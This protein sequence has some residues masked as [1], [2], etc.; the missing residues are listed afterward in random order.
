MTNKQQIQNLRDYAELAWASYGYFHYFL[1]QH[2][3]PHY[4][5]KV[6]YID[7]RDE[8][9]KDKL[10]NNKEKV[11]RPI[12]LID[13][14]DINYNK[15]AVFEYNSFIK[16][17][18]KVGE[19]NGDMTLGQIKHFFERYDLL[20]H[21]PN[22]ESGFSAT[23]FGEKQTNKQ[24]QEKSSTSECGYV[25]YILAIRGT[26]FK[27]NQAWEDIIATDGSL[28]LSSTPKAQYDD[29]IHFYESCVR[30]YPQIKDKDSLTL[31]GH[32]LG[33]ALAQLLA[34]SLCDSHNPN[35]IKALYT[36]NAPGA[37]DLRPPYLLIINIEKY[38][39]GL[40][41][42]FYTEIRDTLRDSMKTFPMQFETLLKKAFD[43]CFD[44]RDKYLNKHYALVLYAAAGYFGEVIPKFMPLEKVS[45]IPYY[46][47]LLDNYVAHQKNNEYKLAIHN[48]IYHCESS[49]NPYKN[50]H[51]LGSPISK[52]GIKLGLH[53]NNQ[54][55]DAT[56]LHT[57][58][59]SSSITGSHSIIPLTQT[60]YFYS[61]L[62]ELESNAEILQSNESDISR[63]L[64]KLNKVA[65]AISHIL[66]DI[67]IHAYNQRLKNKGI[68]QY[69]TGHYADSVRLA[70]SLSINPPHYL[71]ATIDKTL[72]E[73][74][75]HTNQDKFIIQKDNS[76]MIEGIL[77]LQNT[78]IFLQLLTQESM[79]EA[80]T[81]VASR[82]SNPAILLAIHERLFFVSAIKQDN[83]IQ[84]L[85]QT[86]NNIT[87]LLKH[88]TTRA[89]I[90]C[91]NLEHIDE[92]LM[93]GY[94]ND[95]FK[96]YP[97]IDK[98]KAA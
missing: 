75:L 8:N 41:Q 29:M 73:A 37:R 82:E 63:S 50:E 88:N 91:Y 72:F 26:E 39:N 74:T 46:Q 96:F 57:I 56:L 69:T 59:T 34:L 12:E 15:C 18:I 42:H 54:Y 23:L 58:N 85:I 68:T 10:D 84:A 11:K 48:A 38:P 62:L 97:F 31:T 25:N 94:L 44:N 30:D 53:K 79:R 3:K 81:N 89:K 9:G 6:H 90:F 70:E 60:L 28:L 80:A 77:Y 1:E 67:E 4:V 36:Y 49:E 27:F 93:R 24:T 14:L 87:T 35:N 22:T 19:V 52:L 32:S 33:G 13:I 83:H 78:N 47:K 55:S 20:K 16:S 5:D 92:K 66:Y 2:N 64:D 65:Q 40:R 45:H 86:K 43:E 7:D 61:Y 98:K 76:N 95:A 71:F 21:C 51:Y 17:Y